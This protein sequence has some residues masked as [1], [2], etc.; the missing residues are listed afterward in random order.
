MAPAHA[1][2][3]SG[4]FW[5][6]SV[7]WTRLFLPL[8]SA[9]QSQL[10]IQNSQGVSQQLQTTPHAA[11]KWI[12]LAGRHRVT[13][14]CRRERGHLLCWIITPL[15][16]HYSMRTTHRL[17]PAIKGMGNVTPKLQLRG[18]ERYTN[19]RDQDTIGKNKTNGWRDYQSPTRRF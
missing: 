1:M 14:H 10:L 13:P 12:H 4:K 17:T 8:P 3:V 2:L 6:N 16:T 7:M 15:N 11:A 18:A 19:S 5:T 9:F